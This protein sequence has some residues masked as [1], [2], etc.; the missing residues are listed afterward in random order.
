MASGVTQSPVTTK[1]R[2]C[3]KKEL[4]I[5]RDAMACKTNVCSHLQ[6]SRLR[7]WSAAGMQDLF[8]SLSNVYHPTVFN[9]RSDL[10]L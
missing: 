10:E 5:G 9:F 6:S 1:G 4:L 7:L 3:I 8:A 2:A